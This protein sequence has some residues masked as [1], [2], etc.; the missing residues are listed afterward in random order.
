MTQIIS[1]WFYT[2]DLNNHFKGNSWKYWHLLFFSTRSWGWKRWLCICVFVRGVLIWQR[3]MSKNQKKPSRETA[4]F[5]TWAILFDS[6]EAQE[7]TS[8]QTVYCTLSPV[9]CT[10]QWYRT[11]GTGCCMWLS[12][13]IF[14]GCW[15]YTPH[16]KMKDNIS[17]ECHWTVNNVHTFHMNTHIMGPTVV[18]PGGRVCCV[19]C[20]TWW[21]FLRRSSPIS[22]VFWRAASETAR[23][24]LGH[25][26]WHTVAVD[27]WHT[28]VTNC[29]EKVGEICSGAILKDME[30]QPTSPGYGLVQMKSLNHEYSEGEQLFTAANLVFMEVILVVSSCFK[31]AVPSSLDSI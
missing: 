29:E 30:I 27:F 11:H 23:L 1:H 28:A 8:K 16:L 26:Q 3:C 7:N 4:D 31:Y 15:N 10:Y 22:G 24:G 9:M 5:L 25:W 17:H 14:V 19:A 2:L 13:W 18:W 12:L 6:I 21:Y 20:Q